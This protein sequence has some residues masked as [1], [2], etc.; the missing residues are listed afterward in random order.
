M[1]VRVVAVQAGEMKGSMCVIT[2]QTLSSLLLSINGDSLGPGTLATRPA[3]KGTHL[4]SLRFTLQVPKN[5]N[6][7]QK[8]EYSCYKPSQVLK[9]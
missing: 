5:R 6:Y 1:G 8:V 2:A 4:Y 7:H 9:V 3:R